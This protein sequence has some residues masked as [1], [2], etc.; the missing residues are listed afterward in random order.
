MKFSSISHKFVL[1]AV[2]FIAILLVTIAVGTYSYFRHTAQKLILAQQLAMITGMASDLDYSLATAHKALIN[3]AAVAPAGCLS[4]HATAQKW[5]HDSAGIRTYFNHSIIILDRAGKLISS[6]PEHPDHYGMSFAHRD[7]FRK[8]VASGKPYKSLPFITVAN[9]HPVIMMTALI[10]GRDGSVAG[11]LCGAIDLLQA[12]G[13][14]TPLRNARCGTSG[15]LYLFAPDRTMIMHPDVSRI[16]TQD[17]KPGMNR[18][19]DQALR[20]FE[21]S[22]E[23]VNSK[24]QQFLVSFKRLQSTGWILA[25][26]Y[27]VSESYQ[28]IIR[29]RNFYLL[30]M[31]FALLISTLLAWRFSIGVT[32][33]LLRFTEDIQ[34]LTRPDSDKRLRLDA[35]RRDELGRLAA[36]FNSKLD[37]VQRNS[38]LVEQKNAEL[39]AALVRAEA[40]T[41]AKS[42][43]LATMSHEI[44]T[45]MNGVIG[46]TGLLLET[47]LDE[48]Q[49]Q[50]AEIANKSGEN[51]LVLINDILDFS[52]IEAGKLDLEEVVFDLRQTVQESVAV[53]ALRAADAGLEL[54]CR[55]DP[56]VPSLLMGDAGRLR[57]VLTNLAGNAIKFTRRGAVVIGATLD[58]QTGDGAV[59]R[60]EVSDTGIGIPEER[61][62]AIF[63]PFTQVDES[64]T[65]KY[66]GTGLGLAICKQL[67][68]LMGGEIG[69]E[70]EEGHGS[71][72]WFTVSLKIQAGSA[73]GPRGRAGGPAEPGCQLQLPDWLELMLGAAADETAGAGD[74][75][76]GA[77]A[78]RRA[79]RILL[80]E[81]NLINQRV[82][83]SILDRL[84]YR[85]DLV[86]NGRE[87]VRALQQNDYDLVLMDCQ[88]P[89]LDGFDA[90]RA[91]RDPGSQ[92]R[93]P[94]VT[95]IAMTA[96]A[97]TGD[98]EKCL[99]AG[100][101]DYL[102]KPI[103]KAGLAAIL[104]KWLQPD[105]PEA[106]AADP[107]EAAA[108]DPLK[109]A[110]ADPLENA[111]GDPPEDAAANAPE[112]TVAQLAPVPGA[113]L[114]NWEELLSNFEGDREFVQSI[115][116][117]ALTE[118]PRS[119]ASLREQ[120]TVGDPEEIC[121]LSHT[122]KGMA[123]YLCTPALRDLALD[124][125]T[126]ARGGD[127][128]G[129]REILPELERFAS[130]TVGAIGAS[131]HF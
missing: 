90:T 113:T 68:E 5:L 110:A 97:M 22:G 88:M 14:F 50:F 18:L 100:M 8:T 117:D 45:P 131:L 93:N 87:A 53:L 31:L 91:V 94:R 54:V 85:A 44:R 101:D 75:D 122:I 51:L 12:D 86:K 16:M 40:A 59:I 6:S 43:F 84:G 32:R 96:N 49:R 107:V 20:G 66:G 114:F 108:A 80:A 74:A 7:Y 71:R 46:M 106:A 63:S 89:E 111:V 1:S 105:A 112:G 79:K 76:P 41:T 103:K 109:D 83:Q 120:C 124:L 104:E 95:I 36:S 52:K 21:G 99:G 82:A 13:L 70:S 37:E 38:A 60:F 25:A 30:G 119:V 127:L 77:E 92:V 39:A 9:D 35:S 62:A 23:T 27:P 126:A 67:T 19:F 81:D 115:L 98:R 121:L 72:F 29:F 102:S 116:N 130:L 125:E 17:I 28:P 42:Q 2:L 64:T 15:Y 57:Q 129:A 48:E 34:T 10:R 11:L 123:A 26:N 61:Q 69:L 78:A 58:S 118:I 24:G 56:A 4:D 47:E 3:V 65:R 73:P 55:I 128:E 33:P